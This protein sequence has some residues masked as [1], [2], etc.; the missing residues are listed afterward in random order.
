MTVESESLRV[1]LD[2]FVMQLRPSELESVA[3]GCGGSDPVR[4][5][6][7]LRTLPTSDR[8]PA[9][10]LFIRHFGRRKPLEQAAAEIGMDALRA[11]ALVETYSRAVSTASV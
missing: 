7:A 1:P 6:Q 10:E 5:A 9:W 2:N 11:R 8:A 4:L 3:A